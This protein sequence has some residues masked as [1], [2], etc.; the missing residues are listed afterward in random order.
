MNQ[1]LC[2]VCGNTVGEHAMTLARWKELTTTP[3]PK[4]VADNPDAII[5]RG[6]LEQAISEACREFE[7]RWQASS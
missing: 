1:T 2:S 3:L 4:G 5:C 7:N 6:C